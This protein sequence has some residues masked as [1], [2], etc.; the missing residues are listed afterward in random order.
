MY[1][2]TSSLL[3]CFH[4]HR[5]EELEPGEQEKME[6]KA[7]LVEYLTSVA[8][9]CYTDLQAIKDHGTKCFPPHYDILDKFI[10]WYHQ[11]LVKLVSDGEWSN[12]KRGRNLI[13]K[14][15]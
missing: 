9:F 7:W 15:L 14:G 3:P 5:F 11:C 1:M 6:N 10:K 8:T 4:S 13:R 2:H 12:L